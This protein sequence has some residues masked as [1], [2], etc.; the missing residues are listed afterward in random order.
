MLE[1]YLTASVWIGCT[2]NKIAATKLINSGRNIVHNLQ[3]KG[4]NFSI[5]YYGAPAALVS[6]HHH[7]RASECNQ[8]RNAKTIIFCHFM[9]NWRLLRSSF[10][11]CNSSPPPSFNRPSSPYTGSSLSLNHHHRHW[12]RTRITMGHSLHY[13]HAIYTLIRAAMQP[14]TKFIIW[15]G[16]PMQHNEPMWSPPSGNF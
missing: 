12:N 3:I 11:C 5:L 9:L 13:R 6:F 14:R 7:H 1:Q 4:I 10:S 15:N 16:R 2:E 8:V